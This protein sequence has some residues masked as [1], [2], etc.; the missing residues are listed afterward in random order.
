MMLLDWF[1]LVVGLGLPIVLLLVGVIAGPII[2]RRHFADLARR[3]QGMGNILLSDLK[4]FPRGATG[5]VL[6]AGEAVV[7]CDRWK[8]VMARLRD[9]IGGEVRSFQTIMERARREALLRLVD[10]ARAVGADTIVNLRFETA[11]VGGLAADV[12]TYG[13]AVRR[14]GP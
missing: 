7:A 12:L 9:L 1:F 5:G 14:A 11:E 6:V 2:E 3:E 8:Q 4:V 13:T 10:E